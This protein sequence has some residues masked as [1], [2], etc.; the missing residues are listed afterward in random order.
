M[1]VEL[2]SFLTST[3]DAGDW[4]VSRPSC[5]TPGKE[6]RYPLNMRI[7]GPLSL[8]GSFEEERSLLPT[9]GIK[10]RTILDTISIPTVHNYAQCVSRILQVHIQTSAK[11]QADGT[12]FFE[13]FFGPS[14]KNQEHYFNFWTSTSNSK[15]VLQILEQYLKFWSNTSNYATTAYFQALSPY[16]MTR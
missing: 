12:K 7:G 13:I 6:V 15:V 11:T 3:L 1:E 4:S 9:S 10:Y 16:S 8:F 2:N 14:R 5:F